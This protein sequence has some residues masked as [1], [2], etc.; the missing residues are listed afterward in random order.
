MMEL[1]FLEEEEEQAKL[2]LCDMWGHSE[3]L[4][5]RHRDP[6][7]RTESAN[8]LTLD[9][10]AS[11]TEREKC[12]LF[13]CD[14]LLWQLK[15]RS[16]ALCCLKHDLYDENVSAWCPWAHICFLS[17]S[18]DPSLAVPDASSV[19]A[20]GTPHSNPRPSL[21]HTFW[22]GPVPSHLHAW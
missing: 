3:K 5:A 12:L 17:N 19:P 7:P 15:R 6:A 20:S 4:A 21:H 18:A 11:K 22:P 10:S 8:T 9:F 13:I 1:V 14:I 2:S 16:Q